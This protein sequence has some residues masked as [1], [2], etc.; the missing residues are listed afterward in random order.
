MASSNGSDTLVV[1]AAWLCFVVARFLSLLLLSEGFVL[2]S[3][4]VL[5]LS[6]FLVS[7]V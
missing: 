3:Q 1:V 7:S 4:T 2:D 5:F 6:M